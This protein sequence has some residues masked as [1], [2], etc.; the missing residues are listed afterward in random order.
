MNTNDINAITAT[1]RD[2]VEGMVFN[3][4]AKLRR[5]FDA[6]ASIIGHFVG[7][8]FEWLSLDQFIAAV[9]GP[10]PAPAGSE[11]VWDV[12]TLDITGDTAVVKITDE[13]AG[14]RFTD[15]LSLLKREGNW[16]IVNKIYYLHK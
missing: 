9:K 1:V 7:G 2:Y 11:P 6:K 14:L 16:Q 4:D 5:A 15:T 8:K 3:D 12:V 13:F 10:G